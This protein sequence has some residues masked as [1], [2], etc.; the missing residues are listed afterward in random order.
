MNMQAMYRIDDGTDS[1]QV[2]TY[3]SV[4]MILSISILVAAGA[5]LRRSGSRVMACGRT[6]KWR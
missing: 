1:N 5:S 6:T 3:A 4:P 2:I